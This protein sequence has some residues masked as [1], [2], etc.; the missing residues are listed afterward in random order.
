MHVLD[1][2]ICLTCQ[3][4]VLD[5]GECVTCRGSAVAARFDPSEPRDP[6]SGKWSSGAGVV[7]DA[8]KLADR[9]DLGDG[10]TFAGSG[11]VRDNTG[12]LSAV[13]AAVDTPSGRKI[14]LGLVSQED[15][16]RPGAHRRAAEAARGEGLPRA[17]R[18][19]PH[20]RARHR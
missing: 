4:H 13:L 10:E 7:K 5:N 3:P 1:N 19:R 2:G 16:G 17:G 20:W 18:T 11:K 14:R 9:I 15:E 6:H 12:D 8:L